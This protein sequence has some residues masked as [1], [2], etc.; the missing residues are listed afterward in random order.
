MLLALDPCGGNDSDT[1]FPLLYK[2]VPRQLAPELTVIFR[3][4]NKGGNFTACWRL[5][6]VVTVPKESSSSDVGEYRSIS[7]TPLL[8]KV[9]EKIVAAKL[10]HYMKCSSL[11]APS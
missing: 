3:H 10:S 7:I 1:M 2:Q 8:P 5:A 11:L 6:N 9:F 4:L